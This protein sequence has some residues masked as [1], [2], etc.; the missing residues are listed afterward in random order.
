MASGIFG[1]GAW[2][3]KASR[4]EQWKV[5]RRDA[6]WARAHAEMAE[7]GGVPLGQG[8]DYSEDGAGF[9][10][11]LRER[12][13]LLLADWGRVYKAY[14]YEEVLEWEVREER[15][16]MAAGAGLT[17]A[18]AAESSALFVRVEDREISMWRVSMKDKIVRERWLEIL[19]QQLGGDLAESGIGNAQPTSVGMN[20]RFDIKG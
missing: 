7:A 15:A 20:N 2:P 6:E 10:I 18:R 8:W 14:D 3:A 11:N 9:A 1:L 19:S 13:I 12:L 5:P 4:A 16:G 17:G